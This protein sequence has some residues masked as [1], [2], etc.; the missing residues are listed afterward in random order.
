MVRALRGCVST[1]SVGAVS[2]KEWEDLLE[3][4]EKDLLSILRSFKPLN[5]SF[6]IP[7]KN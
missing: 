4:V 2:T 7:K 3:I 5:K 6:E 1:L